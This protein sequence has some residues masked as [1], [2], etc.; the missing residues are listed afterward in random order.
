MNQELGLVHIDSTEDVIWEPQSVDTSE[1]YVDG[2]GN[3]VVTKT[4]KRIII[5]GSTEHQTMMQT[6]F[7]K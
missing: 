7:V 1:C 4:T 2:N 3:F 5:Y 6:T